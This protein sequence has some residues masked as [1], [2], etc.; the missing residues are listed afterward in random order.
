MFTICRGRC[1]IATRATW[2]T[3]RLAMFL[4]SLLCPRPDGSALRVPQNQD[5]LVNL[6]FQVEYHLFYTFFLSRQSIKPFFSDPEPA[7]KDLSSVFLPLLPP[8]PP[9]VLS[10]FPGRGFPLPHFP[11]P[12][13]IP[14]N[15]ENVPV[16]PNIP[17]ISGWSSG[18]VYKYLVHKGVSDHNANLFIE[19]VNTT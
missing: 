4:R 6:P 5:L 11:S 7:P 1:C 14:A 13:V 19:Q 17:D 18:Q 8:Q 10:C 3:T 15:W 2:D 9:G 16:D 12:E